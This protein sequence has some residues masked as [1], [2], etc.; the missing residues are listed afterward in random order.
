MARRTKLY[1]GKKSRKSSKVKR[2]SSKL[3][4]RQTRQRGKRMIQRGGVDP[5]MRKDYFY[6]KNTRDLRAWQIQQPDAHAQ[7]LGASPVGAKPSEFVEINKQN[8]GGVG[9]LA[10]ILADIQIF[11]EAKADGRQ[12]G[13]RLDRPVD[14]RNYG[15]ASHPTWAHVR[16]EGNNLFMY[17][18]GNRL[19]QIMQAILMLQDI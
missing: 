17:I 3:R 2:K 12:P 13:R 19:G 5:Q 15:D 1:R 18:G 14:D 10:K 8:C 9:G 11:K 4:K 7:G 6:Y 16:A